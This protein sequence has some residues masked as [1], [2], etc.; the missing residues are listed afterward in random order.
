MTASM[1]KREKGKFVTGQEQLEKELLSVIKLIRGEYQK[2]KR[3]IIFMNSIKMQLR[4]K[5]VRNYQ[6]L[7]TNRVVGSIM[8]SRSAIISGISKYQVLQE[9]F[10]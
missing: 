8:V 9:K 4:S 2:V 7:W 6:S 3:I 5:V 10:R 1:K